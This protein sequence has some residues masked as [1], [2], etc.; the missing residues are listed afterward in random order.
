MFSRI[1]CDNIYNMRENEYEQEIS[2]SE[3]EISHDEFSNCSTLSQKQKDDREE[4]IR[5]DRKKVINWIFTLIIGG[6]VVIGGTIVIG[7]KKSSNKIAMKEVGNTYCVFYYKTQTEGLT[8]RLYNDFEEQEVPLV[9]E[10]KND[11]GYYVGEYRF[12]NLKH[13]THYNISLDGKAVFGSESKAQVSF[14]TLW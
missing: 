9:Y 2:K 13:N 4:K 14:T 3:K 7:K 8:A 1:M 12:D 6:T 10:S 11:E 5:G